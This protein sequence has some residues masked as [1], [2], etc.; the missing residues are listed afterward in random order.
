[1]IQNDL[2]TASEDA[3]YSFG[4]VLRIMELIK[5]YEGARATFTEARCNPNKVPYPQGL[6]NFICP[7]V[8]L[9]YELNEVPHL[10]TQAQEV[11]GWVQDLWY[12]H[13]INRETPTQAIKT[14]GENR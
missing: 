5:R 11:W 10:R 8:D 7:H 2:Q 6:L 13:E 9:Y 12:T 14:S 4:D 1:M 3:R